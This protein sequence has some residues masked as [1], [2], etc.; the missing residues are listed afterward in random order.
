MI[1]RTSR[2]YTGP[3]AQLKDKSSGEYV[4]SVYRKFPSGESVNYVPYT[5]KERDELALVADAFNIQP[6]FWWKITDLN[7]ELLDPF[8]IDPGTVIRIPY[9]N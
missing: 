9:G 1:G 3:I 4:I 2:Y 6:K 8:Y 5:W 7:P